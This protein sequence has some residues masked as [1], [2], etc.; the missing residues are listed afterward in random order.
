MAECQIEIR[1]DPDKFADRY[2]E[3][4]RTKVLPSL[5]AVLI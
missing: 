4:M 5:S 2:V 3:D 1:R